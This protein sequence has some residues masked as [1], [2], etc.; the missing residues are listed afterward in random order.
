MKNIKEIFE[1]V[2][3]ESLEL[4]RANAFN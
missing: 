3:D 2:L 4:R 1:E